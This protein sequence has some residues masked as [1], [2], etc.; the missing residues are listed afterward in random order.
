[1]TADLTHEGFFFMRTPQKAYHSLTSHPGSLALRGGPY[2]IMEDEA[3]SMI[4]R[5]QTAFTGE[6]KIDFEFQPK[7][8]GQ[9][10]GVAVWWSKWCH[11]AV[12]L[13]GKEGGE[14]ELVYRMPDD[15]H[16]FVVSLPRG[17]VLWRC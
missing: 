12:I 9:A 5:K 7:E 16:D 13:R 6:W 3:V 1:M 10:A 17:A 11:G 14:L 15:G 4:L 2:A 8:P